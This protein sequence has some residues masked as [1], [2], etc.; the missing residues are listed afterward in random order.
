LGQH[1]VDEDHVR[2][3]APRDAQPL[4]TVACGEDA[5]PLEAKVELEA[6]QDRRVVLD[7]ENGLGHQAFPR[8]VLEAGRRMRNTEPRPTS[9]STVMRPPWAATMWCTM[10]SPSPVP[11]TF[12]RAGSSAR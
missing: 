6:A 2:S 4:L 3:I 12:G 9:L 8:F 7:E 5:E 1:H 11:S 10:A